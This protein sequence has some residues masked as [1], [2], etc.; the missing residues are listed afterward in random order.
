MTSYNAWEIDAEAKRLLE[1]VGILDV[2]QSVDGV[3]AAVPGL[4][5][6]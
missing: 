1:A 6:E 3:S 5:C 4:A 2:N